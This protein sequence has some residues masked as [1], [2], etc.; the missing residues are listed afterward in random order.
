M[1]KNKKTSHQVFLAKEKKLI[2][3]DCFEKSY[4][5]LNREIGCETA[6]LLSRFS[7]YPETF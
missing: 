7:R 6:T 4:G 1:T 3:K 2:S 5:T